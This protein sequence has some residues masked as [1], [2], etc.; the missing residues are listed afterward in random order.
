MTTNPLPLIDEQRCNGCGRCVEVCPTQVLDLDTASGK[1]YLR[2]PDRCSYC[3]ACE[4][5]CPTHAIALPFVI[6]LQNQEEE[7]TG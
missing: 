4:E 3:T 2:Y 7:R 5:I 1:A 6:I